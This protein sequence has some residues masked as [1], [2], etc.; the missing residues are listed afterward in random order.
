LTRIIFRVHAIQRM[1]MRRIT[2]DEVLHA[3]EAGEVIEEYP[4]DTPYPSRLILGWEGQRPLHVVAAYDAEDDE[5]I[6]ITVYKPDPA[7]W[8]SDYKRRKP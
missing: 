5:E 7:H 3:I 1:F 4:D 2:K 6:I 8:E